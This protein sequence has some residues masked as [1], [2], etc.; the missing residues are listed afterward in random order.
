MVTV[1]V[2]NHDAACFSAK[3]KPPLYS[4]E[5]RQGFPNEIHRHVQFHSNRNCD[6]GIGDVMNARDGETERAEIPPAEKG[7]ELRASLFG[8]DLSSSKVR[9]QTRLIL[10]TV[11]LIAL[12]DFWE[13]PAESLIVGT[14]DSQSIER[15]LIDE[16]KKTF[17]DTFHTAVMIEMFAV[18]IRHG[19]D[20]RRKAQE[21]TIALVR[22]SNK[23]LS[24]PQ[25]GMASQGIHFSTNDHRRVQTALG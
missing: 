23:Q 5:G 3:M 15:H 13:Q 24:A 11:G 21:R 7:A 10:E 12:H 6:Q 22:F 17:R 25:P 9:R 2:H 1:V 16:L 14:Q 20:G 18:E 4:R 8:T 19:H